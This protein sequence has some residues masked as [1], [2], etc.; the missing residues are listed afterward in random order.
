MLQQINTWCLFHFSITLFKTHLISKQLAKH[1]LNLVSAKFFRCELRTKT[2]VPPLDLFWPSGEL[3]LDLHSLKINQISISRNG[4]GSIT[5]QLKKAHQ[6]SF[7]YFSFF[8]SLS[9][10]EVKL[11]RDFLYLKP[12]R[13]TRAKSEKIPLETKNRENTSK[14]METLI[15]N[16]EYPRKMLKIDAG[17]CVIHRNMNDYFL[18]MHEMFIAK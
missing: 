3:F 6:A 15:Q 10:C 14:G 11:Y 13:K 9:C 16:Q 1:S 2:W 12:I 5:S 17:L 18:C 4:R 7:F 8:F